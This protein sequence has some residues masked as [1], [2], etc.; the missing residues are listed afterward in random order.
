MQSHTF[1]EFFAGAGL[2]RLGLPPPWRCVW[3]ND[4]DPRK[5]EVYRANFGHDDLHLGDVARVS[6][7]DLPSSAALAWASFPCQDLSLAG[8]RRGMS[9][10]R[11]G[12]FWAFWQ[13]MRDLHDRGDR[14][15]VLVLENVVGLLHGDSF[16]GLCESL[17]AL[18]L[19]FGAMVI[20]AKWFLPQSRPRVFVLAVD[21]RYE[22]PAHTTGLPRG[23]PWFPPA[24]WAAYEGLP[25]HL[26]GLWRWW[27]LPLPEDSPGDVTEL[28]EEEP[29]LVAWN[30][31]EQ[32][33]YLLGMMSPTNREK[34]DLARRRGGRSVGLLY[35]RTRDG[36]QRAEVRFDGVA[37]CLRTPQGGSSR[38]TVLVI[39]DGR[40]R[41]RLLSPREAARL[42]GA[43]DS[44]ALPDHYNNAYL[45]MGDGVAVPVVRWLAE[46]LLSPIADTVAAGPNG[47][48]ASPVNRHRALSDPSRLRAERL[49]AVWGAQHR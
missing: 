27:R 17:A 24:L 38:Q 10:G 13:L 45:A 37:G 7:A 15:P 22:L 29:T 35:R 49:A 44:Y 40:I 19:Q 11:S 21:S 42:M 39:E 48:E 16:A 31:D 23:M 1:Y 5:A 46:H 34:V 26:R 6:A 14:P 9:A 41:S 25:A 30:S 4:Y 20:D 32:T 18:D 28:I 43:P 3:A 12:T 2:V 36:V 33:D 47:R 8:W